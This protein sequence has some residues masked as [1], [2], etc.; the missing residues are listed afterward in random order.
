[1]PNC[2]GM[3]EPPEIHKTLEDFQGVSQKL[4][5]I[6]LKCGD[7]ADYDVGTICC[8]PW[9]E[10]ES[11]PLRYTFSS[12]F[13][14]R[15]CGG[16]GPWEIVDRVKVL[17]TAVRA[18]LGWKS[19]KIQFVRCVMFDGF[20]FQTPAM[21]EEHLLELLQKDPD[22]AFLHTRL[23][24]LFRNCGQKAKAA[25]WYEKSLRLDPNDLEA[26]H[27]L[28]IFAIENRNIN[29]AMLHAVELV[30]SFLDGHKTKSEELTEGLAASVV[31]NLR[32]A[33]ASFRDLLFGTKTGRTASREENFMRSVMSEDGDEETVVDN[34]VERLLSDISEPFH[35]EKA[36]DSS[37]EDDTFL[38]DPVPSLAALVTAH[39]L[40]PRKLKVAFEADTRGNIRVCQKHSIPLTDSG[41]IVHWEV[42]ALAGLFRGHGIPPNDIDRYPPEYCPHF[43]LIEKH[44]LTMCDRS[45]DRTDQEMEEIYSALRRRPD[46]RSLGEVHDF[47]WQAAALLLGSHAVSAAEHNAIFDTLGRSTRKWGLRPVSRNYIGYLRDTFENPTR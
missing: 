38:F 11:G 10:A 1:M 28:F 8:D 33:P 31:E 27:P 40:N 15:K 46:G 2:G 25:E 5:L 34:A 22:N 9:D 29:D 17:A 6:C 18:A 12:Y 13:R 26:R 41:R 32:G 16:A 14:C 42:P 39:G 45:R 35:E 36:S 23:G 37:D 20:E 7:R 19:E 3:S 43:F 24:N 47:M 30:R 44:F 21:G 4:H